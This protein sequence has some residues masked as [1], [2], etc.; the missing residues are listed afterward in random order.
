MG[1]ASGSSSAV[2]Q[3]PPE[4]AAAELRCAKCRWRVKKLFCEG[5]HA[6]GGMLGRFYLESFVPQEWCRQARPDVPFFLLCVLCCGQVPLASCHQGM[7]VCCELN[8]KHTP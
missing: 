7:E 8:L 4:A 6:W 2:L 1:P 5:M 3:P